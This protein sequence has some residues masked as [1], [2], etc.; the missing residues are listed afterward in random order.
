LSPISARKTKR[1][2]V[3][4]DAMSMEPSV[5][6]LDSGIKSFQTARVN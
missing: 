1:N 2:A 5:T 4:I 3:T 6:A